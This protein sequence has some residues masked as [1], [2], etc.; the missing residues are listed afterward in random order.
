MAVKLPEFDV[1][2]KQ[3]R[4]GNDL[5]ILPVYN[6][7][8]MLRLIIT[9]LKNSYSGNVL[10]IDDN[11]NDGSFEFL[12]KTKK[13]TLLR[14]GKNAGAGGVLLQ[15]FNYAREQGFH[16]II[17]MDS[18]GQHHACQIKEFFSALTKNKV[19]MVWGT[20]YPAGFTRLAK[21]FQARQQN[22]I[23]VTNRLNE[24]TGWGITDSFCGFRAYSGKA[25]EKVHPTETGYG[26]LLQFAVLAWKAGLQ[27]IEHPVPLI[28]LDET[29][30]FNQNFKDA[31][32]RLEYYFS[33]IEEVLHK[34]S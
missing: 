33:V 14:N 6:E 27:M 32:I 18:D 7:M 12:E 9:A 22:N 4:C 23:A 11:S 8:P 13:I 34:E 28:Y 21:S 15:G 5:A 17:T 25:L 1:V 3:K 19:D 24:I 16:R 10:V 31:K 20:R 29:R 30:D 2:H 26:M